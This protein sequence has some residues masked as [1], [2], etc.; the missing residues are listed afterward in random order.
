V[1]TP[2]AR[3]CLARPSRINLDNGHTAQGALV[4]KKGFQLGKC[5]LVLFA[6]AANLRTGSANAIQFLDCHRTTMFCGIVHQGLIAGRRDFLFDTLR[7]SAANVNC[8]VLEING[9]DD[10]VHFLLDAPPTACLSETIGKIKAKTASAFLDKFGSIFYGKHKR[11]LWSS[12]FFVASTGGVTLE[13]L[14]AYVQNQ[15]SPSP[16]PP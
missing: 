8:Q 1:A 14:K 2:A 13:T 7:E 10:H 6:V 16:N 11:T 5:P 3:A 15:N 4:A 9:Q 12:G